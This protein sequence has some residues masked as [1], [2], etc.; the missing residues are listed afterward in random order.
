MLNSPED[1]SILTQLAANGK[2]IEDILREKR[3]MNASI[4][5]MFKDTYDIA[6][7]N[8]YYYIRV[9]RDG[10]LQIP[11]VVREINISDVPF[12]I[13]VVCKFMKVVLQEMHLFTQEIRLINFYLVMI[14]YRTC[15]VLKEG[16]IIN[17]EK[18]VRLIN[19]CAE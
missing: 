2:T 15:L 3:P 10:K 17:T 6:D 12:L 7:Q 14:N 13:E 19:N 5:L 16:Q 11:G 1:I 9:F 18:T 8:R 4:L